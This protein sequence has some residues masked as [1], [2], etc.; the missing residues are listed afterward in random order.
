MATRA[1]KGKGM[2]ARRE[3]L[4]RGVLPIVRPAQD[5]DAAWM[6]TSHFMNSDDPD[7]SEEKRAAFYERLSE[8]LEAYQRVWMIEDKHPRFRGGF[9]PVG[10]AAGATNDWMLEPHIGWFSWSTRANRLRG[11]VGFLMAQ[12]ADPSLGCLLIRSDDE[13][14]AFF[15]A[16]KR[17]APVYRVGRIPGGRS[18]GNDH[19]FYMRGRRRY[20]KRE[21]GHV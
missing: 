8:H 2:K 10:F 15:E 4:F 13:H 6:W 5:A 3:R 16:I 17:Y 19:L 1:D 21:S 18:Y 12:R 11:V 14:R 7:D 9:G 20:E